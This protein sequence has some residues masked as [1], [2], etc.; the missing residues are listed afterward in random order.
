MLQGESGESNRENQTDI[1]VENPILDYRNI[2]SD[3][4]Y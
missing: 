4:F 3:I 1:L 2:G